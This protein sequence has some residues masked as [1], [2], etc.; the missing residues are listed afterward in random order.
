M[1]QVPQ[2]LT[3]EQSLIGAMLV[4]PTCLPVVIEPGGAADYYAY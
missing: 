3:A 1:R 2:D 4:F